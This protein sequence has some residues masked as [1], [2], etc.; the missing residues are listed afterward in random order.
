M[1]DID[2]S[3]SG[4]T[5]NIA[6][7]HFEQFYPIRDRRNQN[8]AN[9]YISHADRS[10]PVVGTVYLMHGYGGSPVEPCMIVPKELA[11]AAGFDVVA[12]EG[13]ALSAT[14]GDQKKSINMNLYRHKR[15]L[16]AAIAHCQTR[17]D[18]N[19]RYH[20]AWAHSMSCRALADLMVA[21][22]MIQ[23]TFNTVVMNNPYFLPPMRVQ[24]VR[25]KLMARDPSGR[26]WRSL[27]HKSVT[28]MRQI[29]N[30]QYYYPASLY[31]LSVPLPPTWMGQKLPDIAGRLS[32]YINSDIRISFV[33]GTKD[34]MAEYN[35]N[36]EL[37]S[38]LR[39]PNKELASIDGA[40]HSFENALGQYKVSS[41]QILSNIQQK[42][43][44]GYTL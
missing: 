8:L 28:Q 25:D 24:H 18:L 15:A 2:R 16:L 5:T 17:N 7:A 4:L 37:F 10:R 36:V 1:S 31:N 9:V 35:Q 13:V 34:D 12:I 30:V 23:K 32:S 22:P 41:S 21:S 39:V 40:N 38:G 26:M 43:L 11:L 14:C 19:H 29:Q 6:I 3:S 44:G 42:T 20:V 27:L 33:L